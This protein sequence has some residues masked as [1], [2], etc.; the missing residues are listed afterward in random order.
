[1]RYS[2]DLIIGLGSELSEKD[3]VNGIY[4]FI[5]KIR[6]DFLNYFYQ[7]NLKVV[8]VYSHLHRLVGGFKHFLFSPLLGKDSHFD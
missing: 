7:R 8:H 1:M 2:G 5:K 3:L 6:R 4:L